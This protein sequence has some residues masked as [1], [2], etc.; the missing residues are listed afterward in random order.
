MTICYLA[1]Q[2]SILGLCR[3]DS[4]TDPMFIAAFYLFWPN[5][6]RK[7]LERKF[8]INALRGVT[9]HPVIPPP[10][11]TK[12]VRTDVSEIIGESYLEDFLSYGLA[13]QSF[14]EK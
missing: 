1:T 10:E 12:H 8:F 11:A 4:L 3:G 9:C 6:Y 14:P 2:R 5:S 7:S 13:I